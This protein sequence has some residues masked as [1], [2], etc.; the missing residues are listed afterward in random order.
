MGRILAGLG[1][2]PLVP[3]SNRRLPAS[4]QNCNS[5]DPQLSLQPTRGPIRLSSIV[6]NFGTAR[7]ADFS[8][9]TPREPAW[10]A[11]KARRSASHAGA[12]PPPAA[13]SFR[14]PLPLTRHRT[15]TGATCV[16]LDADARSANQETESAMARTPTRPAISVSVNAS[17]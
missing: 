10:I 5:P 1:R 6:W 14:V 15:A 8:G 2:H 3:V 17:K 7:M 16:E 9:G 4:D 11:V 13:E 12:D